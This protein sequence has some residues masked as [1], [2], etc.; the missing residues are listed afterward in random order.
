MISC[1]HSITN[2]DRMNWY[3]Q[4]DKELQL[5]GYM[6]FDTGYPADGLGVK[7]SGSALKG[8]TCDLT[9]EWLNTNSSAVY[10]C[11]SSLHTDVYSRSPAQKPQAAACRGLAACF[12]SQVGGSAAWRD[13]S[14]LSSQEVR[15]RS[16]QMAPKTVSLTISR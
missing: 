10:Y 12:Q 3:R 2:Y 11:A 6:N 9:V 5:L 7:I 15:R 16:V 4:S 1:S 14:R 8:M 13:A